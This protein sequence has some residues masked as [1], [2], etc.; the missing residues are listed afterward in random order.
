MHC[1][2]FEHQMRMRYHHFAGL[3]ADRT[4]RKRLQHIMMYRYAQ[5]R[6]Y[7]QKHKTEKQTKK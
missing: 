6:R 2:K 4:D 1:L 5:L 7:Q 3:H